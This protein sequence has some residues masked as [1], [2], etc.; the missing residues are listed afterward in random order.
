MPYF[1][2]N[3]FP[4]T[5]LAEPNLSGRNKRL[6]GNAPPPD[7]G[8][9]RRKRGIID[10]CWPVGWQ[11][12]ITTATGTQASGVLEQA[13]TFMDVPLPW[14]VD[15]DGN[16]QLSLLNPVRGATPAYGGLGRP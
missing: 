10:R 8:I 4:Q 12:T 9:Y 11:H 7:D 6:A 2:R 15:Y 13:R 16:L 3:L 14:G 5:L 1:T